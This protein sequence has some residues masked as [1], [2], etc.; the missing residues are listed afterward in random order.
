MFEDIPSVERKLAKD[1][2]QLAYEYRSHCEGPND[3]RIMLMKKGLS[4][5]SATKLVSIANSELYI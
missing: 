4:E 1:L 3:T 2:Y 5:E